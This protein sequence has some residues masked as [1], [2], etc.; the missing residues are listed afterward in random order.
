MFIGSLEISMEY[1]NCFDID[2][3]FDGRIKFRGFI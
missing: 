1:F 3:I 2:L